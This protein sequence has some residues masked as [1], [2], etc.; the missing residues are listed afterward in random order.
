MFHSP[1]TIG[2]HAE[3]DSTSMPGFPQFGRNTTSVRKAPTWD[4]PFW[5]YA[6]RR[7]LLCTS[8]HGGLNALAASVTPPPSPS[9]EFPCGAEVGLYIF[10]PCTPAEKTT[11][12]LKA[13]LLRGRRGCFYGRPNPPL[14]AFLILGKRM[15]NPCNSSEMLPL[16][17]YKL[18][19]SVCQRLRS[20]VFRICKVRVISVCIRVSRATE[21]VSS[22][23]P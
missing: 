16:R 19:N 9:S 4:H 22:G 1:V 13:F 2:Q 3:R 6:T 20:R 15:G 8:V 11:L 17:V 12:C 14:G 5:W 18:R 7:L 23:S 10:C 21:C